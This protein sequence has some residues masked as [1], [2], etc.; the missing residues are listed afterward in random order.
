MAI[1]MLKHRAGG[2]GSGVGPFP[3]Y[4]AWMWRRASVAADSICLV[5]RLVVAACYELGVA[6]LLCSG[7][8]ARP[9]DE[10]PGFRDKA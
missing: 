2:S 4:D 6:H 1:C 10:R 5:L 3:G 7:H 8:A 9:R